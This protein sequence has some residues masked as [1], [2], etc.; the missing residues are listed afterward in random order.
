MLH[1]IKHKK[2]AITLQN[3]NPFYKFRYNPDYKLSLG[4]LKKKLA[5]S[6]DTLNNNL[7]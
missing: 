2:R 4:S 6:D 5:T 1:N 7:Q 3:D